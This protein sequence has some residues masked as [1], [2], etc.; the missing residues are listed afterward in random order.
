MYT[1]K[2]TNIPAYTHTYMQACMHTYTFLRTNIHTDTHTHTYI[3]THTHTYIIYKYIHTC[4]HTHTHTHTRER[5]V[6][7]DV[8]LISYTC[9]RI[10]EVPDSNP[11]TLW[12]FPTDVPLASLGVSR[13][14]PGWHLERGHYCFLPNACAHSSCNFTPYKICSSTSAN[15]SYMHIPP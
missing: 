7:A 14:M 15:Y 8:A 12:V 1:H 3:H 11:I 2:L 10:W 5:S 6:I 13:R 4:I 9:T